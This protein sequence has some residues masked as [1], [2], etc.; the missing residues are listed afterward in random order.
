M[1]STGRYKQ[2]LNNNNTTI[3]QYTMSGGMRLMRPHFVDPQTNIVFD[4]NDADFEGYLTK[5]STWLKVRFICFVGMNITLAI[6]HS[7]VL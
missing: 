5:Q 3:E 4:T 2:T 7:V 1:P 6:L